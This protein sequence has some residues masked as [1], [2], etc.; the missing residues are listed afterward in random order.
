MRSKAAPRGK[1]FIT[2]ALQRKGGSGGL[3]PIGVEIVV[4]EAAGGLFDHI[5]HVNG[6]RPGARPRRGAGPVRRGV[7]RAWTFRASCCTPLRD[8]A[9]DHLRRRGR[10]RGGGPPAPIRAG[11]PPMNIMSTPPTTPTTAL[12]VVAKDLGVELL[13][14]EPAFA[15]VGAYGS[16]GERDENG[17]EREHGIE[18]PALTPDSLFN[19]A[20]KELAVASVS[21][22]CVLSEAVVRDRLF[23][24]SDRHA[25][26]H[27]LCARPTAPGVELPRLRRGALWA[28]GGRRPRASAY[29]HG[30][31]GRAR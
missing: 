22:C 19:A 13:I 10:A 1:P 4:V 15:G 25:V 20:H 3:A 11:R 16:S 28:L 6:A 12:S 18:P 7:S 31:R 2:F 5:R 29:T 27:H 9:A 23:F 8:V 26:L 17:T 14:L 21:I 24:R 30:D